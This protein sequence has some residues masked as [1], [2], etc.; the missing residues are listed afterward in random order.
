MSIQK[1]K[2]ISRSRYSYTSLWRI[3]KP[4]ISCSFS[5]LKVSLIS[6]IELWRV[7]LKRTS[8]RSHMGRCSGIRVIPSGHFKISKED[9]WPN[10]EEVN[11][12]LIF[13]RYSS[14]K[15]DFSR[16]KETGVLEESTG[17]GRK[18]NITLVWLATLAACTDRTET[19]KFNCQADLHST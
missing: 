10:I 5:T 17:S 4:S 15:A 9:G 8:G 16:A 2:E 7:K 3:R 14:N 12:K 18:P 13:R 19:C 11:V 6:S 1:Q